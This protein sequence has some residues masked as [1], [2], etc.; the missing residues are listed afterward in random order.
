LQWNLSYRSY[1]INNQIS[2]LNEITCNCMTR[3]MNKAKNIKNQ[4][5]GKH[6]IDYFFYIEIIDTAHVCISRI[7]PLYIYEFLDY[8]FYLWKLHKFKNLNMFI[9]SWNGVS[10]RKS[11]NTWDYAGLVLQAEKKNIAVSYNLRYV[12]L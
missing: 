7:L 12:W 2:L 8:I 1:V 9:F 5:S 4:L 3:E 11:D 6:F 10:N